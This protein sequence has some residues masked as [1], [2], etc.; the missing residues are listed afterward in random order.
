[1]IYLDN[2]ATTRTLPE[3]AEAAMA[4]M[5]GDFFNPAAAYAYG[6]RTE[7]RVNEAR[8]VIAR[9]LK[10]KREEIIFTSGGTESNNAAIFG[11]LKGWR[12]PKRVITTA[13]EHPSVFEAV[14]SLQQSGDVDIVILP[15]N[16]QGYPDMNALRDALSEDTAL[17]SMMHVNNELGTVTDLASVARLIRRYAPRTIFHADGVQAYMKVDTVNLGVDLYS[18]SA[19]KFHAPKGVGALYKRTG[20]R[21]AGGQIGGGQENNLRSG[22]LNVPGI[23]G[24]ERAVMIYEQ[25]LSAW[26]QSMRACKRRLYE[27]LMTIPDVVLNGPSLDE[28]APHILNLSFL[29]VRGEVLLHALE[30][31]D[32]CVSTG[33]ACAA[34]KAG[35]NRILTAAGIIGPRQEG[36]IRFSLCPFNTLEE[37]DRAAQ[38]VYEQVKFLRKYRRR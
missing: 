4:A 10:A 5:T 34:R 27:N 22:T 9:P 30:Q 2:S 25:N 1:M 36:A 3:A 21:F 24:M 12:G 11:S 13:V 16:E 38:I 35:K 33:S 29:G 8:T 31:F 37:M 17:V 15:V 26:R 23:L 14:Q 7:K 18:I 20:V 32:V 19:H 28:A 6:A